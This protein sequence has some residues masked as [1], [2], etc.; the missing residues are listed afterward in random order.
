M[1]KVLICGVIAAVLGITAAYAAP[2]GGSASSTFQVKA[3]LAAT[4]KA[5]PTGTQI[6]DFGAVSPFVAATPT[7][8]ADVTFTCTL[9][10]A[11]SA[12]PSATSGTVSGLP[13]TLSV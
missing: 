5:T 6:I 13:Y 9:G 1:K 2:I 11:P 3:T 8:S 12:T 10:L 7:G 4:C